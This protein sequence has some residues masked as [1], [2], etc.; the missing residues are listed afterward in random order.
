MYVQGEVKQRK[1]VL[2]WESV[3]VQLLYC[4]CSVS[5]YGGGEK[6]RSI[7]SFLASL[8][9]LFIDSFYLVANQW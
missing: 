7:T 5:F 2:V 9:S 4:L 6:S 3:L 8:V 1:Y